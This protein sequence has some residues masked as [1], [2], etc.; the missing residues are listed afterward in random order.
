MTTETT[1][2][3]DLAAALTQT[4][5][6]GWCVESDTH[7]REYLHQEGGPDLWY[8]TGNGRK[9]AGS[10]SFLAPD[11]PAGSVYLDWEYE[12]DYADRDRVKAATS[13]NFTATRSAAA[14]AG[15]WDRTSREACE[16]AYAAS[17]AR[18][19]RFYANAAAQEAA[20]DALAAAGYE[21][22]HATYSGDRPIRYGEDTLT[23]W[24]KADD[25]APSWTIE[26]HGSIRLYRDLYATTAQA[27]AVAEAMRNA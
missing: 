14:I 22:R 20:A 1:T 21:I 15:H 26:T 11:D 12:I 8:A 9:G 6:N 5:G 25:P 23:A 17:L 13:C 16:R 4:T 24:A 3:H 27:I 10:L 7:G 18:I 2:I 19:D